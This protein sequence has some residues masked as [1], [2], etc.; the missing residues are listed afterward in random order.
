MSHIALDLT[1]FDWAI[2][3]YL[4]VLL[5]FLGVRTMRRMRQRIAEGDI[6]ARVG[7]YRGAVA[8]Q[9]IYSAILLAG[10]WWLSRP[11]GGL[12]LGWR[13]DTGALIAWALAIA[14]VL[15]LAFQIWVTATR[16]SAREQLREQLATAGE[17]IGSLMPSSRRELRWFSGLSVTAGI[18]EELVHRG[19]LMAVFWNFGG[20]IPAVVLSTL[21]FTACHAYQPRHLHRV[22]SVGLVMAILYLIG[23][24]VW[25]AMLLHAAIDLTSGWMSWRVNQ[26]KCANATGA[27]GK[28]AAASV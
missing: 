11:L 27:G 8:E 17:E 2:V 7:F 26:E 18:N 9:W 13:T 28:M 19:F 5:P 15:F 23:G 6:D 20:A 3:A 4:A 22:A 21:I 1:A 24:T 10:W 25:P 16:E 14:G 12:G